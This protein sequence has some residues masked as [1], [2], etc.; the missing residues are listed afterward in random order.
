M[1]FLVDGNAN[2]RGFQLKER[3]FVLQSGASSHDGPWASLRAF[4]VKDAKSLKIHCTN[5]YGLA[6]DDKT[7]ESY[8]SVKDGR[9]AVWNLTKG[10]VYRSYIK[11]SKD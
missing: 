11:C 1:Q 6:C 2:D 10:R 7:P 4:V 3:D 9:R 5:P 8:P